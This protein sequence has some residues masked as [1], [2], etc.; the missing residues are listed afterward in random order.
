ML[1]S[2]S[3]P[4][5]AIMKTPTGGTRERSALLT[6]LIP[7]CES[8]RVPFSS[9]SSSAGAGELTEDGDNDDQD[10]RDGVRAG[11]FG[12]GGKGFVGVVL[13]WE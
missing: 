5:P 8:T 11:H 12:S 3:A 1:I 13:V 7:S 6:L 9:D 4:Q 10:G 2:K